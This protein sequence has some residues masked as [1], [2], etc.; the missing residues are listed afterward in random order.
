MKENKLSDWVGKNCKFAVY[1]DNLETPKQL[2]T[3]RPE[4][5]L[6][7][8]EQDLD[9]EIDNYWVGM[10]DVFQRLSNDVENLKEAVAYARD[11]NFPTFLDAYQRA[12]GDAN[13]EQTLM[14]LDKLGQF[15]QTISTDPKY[16]ALIARQVK[17]S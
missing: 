10:K 6:P 12:F 2:V 3:Q 11:P 8:T 16:A 4:S 5:A 17:A 1:N 7:K 14:M 15:A 13:V 9:D